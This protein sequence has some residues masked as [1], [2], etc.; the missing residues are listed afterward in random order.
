MLL[1]IRKQNC[2]KYAMSTHRSQN[3][4]DIFSMALK[5]HS[6]ITRVCQNQSNR[7]FFPN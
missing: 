1:I 3:A 7:V 5:I 6:Q 4:K 2:Y